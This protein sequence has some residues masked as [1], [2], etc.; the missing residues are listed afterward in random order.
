[1]VTPITLERTDQR[2]APEKER[3][4]QRA[5]KR[6]SFAPGTERVPRSHL[7]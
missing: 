4:R 2:E 1:M 6:L 3:I 5:P 7:S